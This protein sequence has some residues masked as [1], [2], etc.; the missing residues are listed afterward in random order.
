MRRSAWIAIGLVTIAVGL[1]L[2]LPFLSNLDEETSTQTF[3]GVTDLV[4]DLENSAL[5]I[6]G[7]ATGTVVEMSVTTGFW[8]AM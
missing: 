1:I 7:G 6:I 8:L 4:F 2:L 5:N 3:D